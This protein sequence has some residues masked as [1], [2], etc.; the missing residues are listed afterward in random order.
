MTYSEIKIKFNED[1]I[2]D[3]VV[4][5]LIKNRLSPN[6]NGL[7]LSQKWV[8]VRTGPNQVAAG[9]PTPILKKG[10]RSAINFIRSFNLDNNSSGE[11]YEVTRNINEVFIKSKIPEI[12]FSNGI[13]IRVLK[14]LFKET[15]SLEVNFTYNN[16]IGNIF[17]INKYEFLPSSTSCSHVKLKVTASELATKI[18]S[19]IP[20]DNNNK[21]PIEFELLRG[22]GLTGSFLFLD[23]QNANGQRVFKKISL[24]NILSSANLSLQV[25]N[26]PNGATIIVNVRNS[27]NLN[28]QYSLDNRNW[29]SSN[30]FDSILP[31]D[32][33]IYVKDDLECVI[34]KNFNV[35]EFGIKELYFEYSK[36]NSI[37]CVKLSE[38]GVI[39]D[40]RIDENRLSNEDD[41][42][43]VYK[44]IY[45]FAKKDII[46]TQI[47]S[48]YSNISVFLVKNNLE[49][50]IPVNKKSNNLRLKDS[51]DAFK[52][53]YGNGKTGIYFVAGK[54]YDF[55]TG[56]DLDNDYS[57]NGKLPEWAK[58]GEYI[59]IDSGWFEIE[60]IIP[61]AEKQ[62]EVLVINTLSYTWIE[63][64]VKVGAI[65]NREKY[66]IYEYSIN[67]SEYLGECF[68]I[69]IIN[70]DDNFSELIYGSE[71]IAVKEKLEGY[72]EFIYSNDTNTDIYYATGIEHKAWVKID[73]ISD[74]PIGK[75]ESTITDTKALLL[76][77]TVNEGKKL[78]TFPVTRGRMIQ[79]YRAF[80]H[81][82]FFIEGTKYVL[83]EEPEVEG[84]LED[85]NLY[86]INATLIK[87]NELYKSKSFDSSIPITGGLLELPSFIKVE[88][89]Y[90]K[91]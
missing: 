34:S 80:F 39:S 13:A 71:E 20:I 36:S 69:K 86:V 33:K 76:N 48:S 5:F 32:Y 85:T 51:R 91:I 12:Q 44:E 55:D 19:P 23:F 47:K 67:M 46:T 16:F 77:G 9:N 58:I 72:S 31:G 2:E 43:L 54:R 53:N 37:R 22:N 26:S 8:T 79:L 6:D 14:N 87:A 78:K 57:L 28:L 62:A 49:Y 52:F 74:A 61:S 21:N 18:I 70:K 41:V 65:Y 56:I 45:P 29:K 10:E 73:D 50:S 84:R 17:K 4:S 15:I 82:H 81:R 35:D 27:I 40:K 90:I 75:M 24:P 25:N 89:S 11:N 66:E 68:T 42:D 59:K 60:N 88:N 83:S 38:G 30:V 64:V 3:S 1:L 7:L 63:T